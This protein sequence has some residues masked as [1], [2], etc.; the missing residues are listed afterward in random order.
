MLILSFLISQIGPGQLT[1]HIN[2]MLGVPRYIR[3][4]R[5]NSYT[6]MKAGSGDIIMDEIGTKKH[7]ATLSRVG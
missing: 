4:Y 6:V 7:P 2:R 5:S 1:F 3:L